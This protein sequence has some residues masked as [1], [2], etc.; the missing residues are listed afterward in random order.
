MSIVECRYDRAA[1]SASYDRRNLGTYRGAWKV[2]TNGSNNTPKTILN[3]CLLVSS[4]ENPIPA[5]YDSYS[6]E[7]ESDAYAYAQQFEITPR[8][9]ESVNM[10]T[11]NVTWSPLP[12]NK[13]EDDFNTNPLSR[14]VEY[15]F[16]WEVYTE[17][18]DKDAEGK[19]IVNTAG[20]PFDIN[21]EMER[22]RSVLVASYNVSNLGMVISKSLRY[23]DAVNSNRWTL[24]TSSIRNR[25]ALCRNVQSSGL[26]TEPGGS[27]YRLTFRV[28]FNGDTWDEKLLSRGFGYLKTADDLSTYT[29]ESREGQNLMDTLDEPLLLK[30]DGTPV[31]PGDPPYFK[32]F[33][34]RKEVDFANIFDYTQV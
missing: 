18:V 10:W 8:E 21:V 29:T 23:Q 24:G 4:P 16:D 20:K 11:I 1:F 31:E 3:Q 19:Q 6:Y 30:E 7:G 25:N 13:Q 26:I 32:E 22:S 34:V 15:A 5:L 28:A 14:G 12:E 33:R 9:N 17:V 27:F 2:R